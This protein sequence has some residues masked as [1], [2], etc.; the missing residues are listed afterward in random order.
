MTSQ[1]FGIVVPGRPVITEFQL[2][3]STKA[4]TMLE[5]PATVPELTF[6]LLPTTVI[7]PGYG[8]ILYY[9][10]PPFQNWVLIGSIDPSKPSGIF[11]TNWANNEEVRNCPVVQ[12]GVSLEPLETINNLHIAGSGVEDR[13]AF[14]HKIALDLFQYMTSFS[15][16]TQNG[17]IAVPTSI[18]DKWMERF[19]RKYRLDPN[20][21]MKES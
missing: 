8:A 5:Q 1:L 14:A 12:L 13:F 20:F 17:M 4:M 10:V 2:V 18:F 6:F 19:E 21:M 11:R 7:P 16:G 9:S 15:S 3:D